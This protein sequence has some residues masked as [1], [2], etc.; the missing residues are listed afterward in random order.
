[1]ANAF[2]KTTL[3]LA[4]PLPLV[5]DF[6]CRPAHRI[7]LASPDLHLRLVEGP[8]R[9]EMGS[10]WVVEGRSYGLTRRMIS[11]IIE[12][13]SNHL[14]TETQREGPFVFWAHTQ[15]FT[16][17]GE[18]TRLTDTILY[19]LPSGMLGLILKPDRVESTLQAG[20]RHRDQLLPGLLAAWSVGE[21]P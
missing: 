5:F 15:H 13:V 9:L 7:A 8:E 1:V 2:F 16:A 4:F 18:G 11:E 14:L 3:H 12:F 17:E 19:Q 21:A 10:L 6:F 20:F